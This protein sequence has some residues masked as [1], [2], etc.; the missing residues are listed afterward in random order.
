MDDTDDGASDKSSHRVVGGQSI[1]FSHWATPD[2]GSLEA[3]IQCA[4]LLR[5][6]AVLMYFSGASNQDI[7]QATQLGSKHIYRLIRERCLAIHP[8]G[9]VYGWRALIPYE[10]IQPYTRKKKIDILDSGYGGSGAL[11]AL[12][13][14]RP[15]LKE[16]FD[17]RIVKQVGN[18]KR[19]QE[20]NISKRRHHLWFLNKLRDLGCEAR[21][22]WPFGTVTLGYATVCK[23][24]NSVLCKNPR[25]LA[26]K[27]GGTDLVEKLK[28][29]DGTQRPVR[30]FMQRVEM[31]A[32]KIDGMF[33]VVL[34]KIDGGT[35]EKIIHRLWVIVI[36]E[37]MSRVVLGYYL[38]LRKEISKDDVLSAIKMALVR[39]TPR[40]VSFSDKSYA[41]GAG[42]LSSIDENLVGLC[43]DETSVDGSLAETC[44]GVKAILRNAVGSVLLEPKNSFSKRRS[45]DDRP[46][47][48]AF[49][50]RIASGG[51]HR[52]SN[53]TGGNSSYRHGRSPEDVA[54]TSRFQYEYAEELLDVLLAN[55]NV[56]SHKGIGGRAPLEYAKFLYKE[57]GRKFRNISADL[58]EDFF[59][60]RKRCIVRGGAAKGR[61]PYVEFFYAR[62]TNEILQNR[63]DLVGSKIWVIQHKENDGRIARASTLNGTSLGV[64]RAGPPWNCLPHSLAVRKSIQ[65][66]VSKGY[67]SIPPGTDAVEAF[68]DY[69]ENNPKKKLPVHSAY[70]ESRRIISEFANPFVKESLLN[71]ALSRAD[72]NGDGSLNKPSKRKTQR[73]GVGLKKASEESNQKS[74]PPRRMAKAE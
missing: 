37:V 41:P 49:F 53:T 45:K 46:Y 10:R 40:Q 73:V 14:V 71:N 2:E 42:F 43:W 8:D 5:K 3:K 13:S 27:Y 58:V 60:V 25:A 16:D 36:I 52:L 32:H 59:S 6:K 72:E 23:Y 65:Q 1:D 21:G 44:D 74:L 12:F 11:Q 67:F 28:T 54:L 34:P 9:R 47:V 24:I 29:G 66:A 55:Y 38:S 63:N 19:L 51:F 62:Y 50:R 17:K 35:Q 4:Y 18:K 61:A 68:I 57:S 39:W 56:T 26:E 20:V 70:L 22:D 33:C 69:V 64:L 48:E 7:K 31:D 15:E 30:E